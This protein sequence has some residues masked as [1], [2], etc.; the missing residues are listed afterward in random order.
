MLELDAGEGPNEE[1][2]LPST[3]EEDLAA[4]PPQQRGADGQRAQTPPAA[5]SSADMS[6][7]AGAECESRAIALQR[8]LDAEQ[9][10]IVELRGSLSTWR[11]RAKRVAGAKATVEGNMVR[12][13]D[14]AKR[15]VDELEV[16]AAHPI[17]I[18]NPFP[19]PACVH[20]YA[21]DGRGC[22]RCR[23]AAPR[24]RQERLRILRRRVAATSQPDQ[25]MRRRAGPRYDLKQIGLII[26]ML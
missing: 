12:L 20:R 14:A 18:T 2:E 11:A 3:D 8:E 22:G 4:P 26:V 19:A 16:S 21:S 13:F 7:G 23:M 1:A 24:R 17:A 9:A 5:A 10:R 15:R 25:R 6:A